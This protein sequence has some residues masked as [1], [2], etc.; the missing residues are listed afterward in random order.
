VSQKIQKKIFDKKKN[1]LPN[2]SVIGSQKNQKLFD[3]KMKPN[4]RVIGSQKI[5]KKNI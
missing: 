4:F 2:F 3:K 1:W 5:Q